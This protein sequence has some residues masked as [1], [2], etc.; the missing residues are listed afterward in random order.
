MAL[1]RYHRGYQGTERRERDRKTQ[2]AEEE[3]A[4]RDEQQERKGGRIDRCGYVWRAERLRGVWEGREGT[5]ERNSGWLASTGN[6]AA[7]RIVS[8]S[9]YFM[10]SRFFPLYFVLLARALHE[11]TYLCIRVLVPFAS[12]SSTTADTMIQCTSKLPDSSVVDRSVINVSLR[13]SVFIFA[14][15]SWN[16]RSKSN[17]EKRNR[18]RHMELTWI[19]MMSELQNNNNNN[20]EWRGATNDYV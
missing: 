17:Q 1:S 4:Q 12:V 13:C 8:R 11:C 7:S 15:R 16:L 3:G 14:P 19:R 20:V 6:S 18:L 5:G 9:T 2:A 10:V